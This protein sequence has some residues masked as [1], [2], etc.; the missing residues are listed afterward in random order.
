M[1]K[2]R[3]TPELSSHTR[4]EWLPRFQLFPLVEFVFKILNWASFVAVL[5]F[6]AEA[7]ANDQL[8]YVASILSSLVCIVASERVSRAIFGRFQF[9]GPEMPLI[10]LVTILAALIL[11]WWMSYELVTVLQSLIKEL[12]ALSK[13]ASSCK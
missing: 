9:S 13:Q 7:T 11:S 4:D 2:R 3:W 8:I 12:V 1:S 6:G 5:R 10:V